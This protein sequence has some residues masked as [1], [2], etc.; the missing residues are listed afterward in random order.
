MSACGA[1]LRAASRRPVDVVVRGPAGMPSTARSSCRQRST[2]LTST[3]GQR[4]GRAALGRG[5]GPRPSADLRCRRPSW[6]PRGWPWSGAVA[7][8][9]GPLWTTALRF[10]P[11]APGPRRRTAGPWPGWT[12][13]LDQPCLVQPRGPTVVDQGRALV[14][15]LGPGPLDQRP[16]LVQGRGPAWTRRDRDWS[17]DVG[18]VTYAD[19]PRSLNVGLTCGFVPSA[20]VWSRGSRCA[21]EPGRRWSGGLVQPSRTNWT[22][23]SRRCWTSGPAWSTRAG[24]ADQS[25]RPAGPGRPAWSSASPG[26]RR[27]GPR[28]QARPRPDAPRSPW[29]GP[30][31]AACPCE[32]GRSRSAMDQRSPSPVR[33][34]RLSR[35][36]SV[37]RPRGSVIVAPPCWARPAGCRN[38]AGWRGRGARGVQSARGWSRRCRAP[39]ASG[40]RSRS[41]QGQSL[42]PLWSFVRRPPPSSAGKPDWPRCGSEMEFRYPEQIR[43]SAVGS[44][45]VPGARRRRPPRRR[46]E[47]RPA[48][49]SRAA[50][51]R[52]HAQ[53]SRGDREPAA[54]SGELARRRRGAKGARR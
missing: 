2:G 47:A 24:P 23:W 14:R 34:H 11:R 3:S 35:L 53:G 36:R 48:G 18:P 26:Q 6:P 46:R 45:R 31:G 50:R 13:L 49:P 42:C 38:G 29:R 19:G 8:G 40:V 41:A 27:R 7:Q 43:P 52:H 30:G 54:G 17:S 37:S 28:R 15:E 4:E 21:R 20:R 25:D 12:K 32:A 39:R 5:G 51:R 33:Q 10:G 1:T 9:T 16:A 22:A 44:V